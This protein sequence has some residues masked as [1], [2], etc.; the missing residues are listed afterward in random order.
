MTCPYHLI[1]EFFEQIPHLW[2]HGIILLKTQSHTFTASA[3]VSNIL[4]SMFIA[5]AVVLSSAG[6]YDIKQKCLGLICG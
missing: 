6:N 1:C 2:V 4:F 3:S 5:I